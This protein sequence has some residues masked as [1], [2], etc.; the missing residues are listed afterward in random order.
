MIAP[1][2]EGV[3]G[4]LAIGGPQ[5]AMGY[6]KLP[7]LTAE[8][9]IMIGSGVA[10][11]DTAAEYLTAGAKGQ[12]RVYLTGDL[13]RWEHRELRLLGRFDRQVKVN[14]VRLELGEVEGVLAS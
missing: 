2:T 11:G 8:R 10:P 3:Q 12:Q 6:V 9:F 4:Q 7:E 1:Q 14:G 13:A 5:L